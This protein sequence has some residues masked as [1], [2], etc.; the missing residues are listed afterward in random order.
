MYACQHVRKK[1]FKYYTETFFVDRVTATL[2]NNIACST[3][4]NT[5]DKELLITQVTRQARYI[6]VLNLRTL[7]ELI[8]KKRNKDHDVML[9]VRGTHESFSTRTSARQSDNTV[10]REL[11]ALSNP[12][13]WS[14]SSAV[15]DKG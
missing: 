6:Y 3:C 10:V 13:I 9:I 4:R 12:F 15:T 7:F 2:M 1:V 11:Q 5:R 14:N 8:K